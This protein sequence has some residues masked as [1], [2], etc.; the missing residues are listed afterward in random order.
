MDCIRRKVGFCIELRDALTNQ[1]IES[2]DICVYANGRLP[3]AKKEK[4]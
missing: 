1:I 3:M 2:G 4:N